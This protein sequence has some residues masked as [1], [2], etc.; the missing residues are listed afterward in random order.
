MSVE[1]NKAV[2]RAWL[3]ARHAHEIEAAVALWSDENQTWLR[4]AF[5]RFSHGFPDLRVTITEMLG[6]GDKVVVWWTLHG[7]HLGVF[8]DIPATGK[9]VNWELCDLYTIADG[10]IKSLVRRAD[11]LSLLQQFGVAS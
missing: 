9:T 2:I 11:Y 8:R 1:E 5:N 4:A 3:A 7:T 10:R 6:E